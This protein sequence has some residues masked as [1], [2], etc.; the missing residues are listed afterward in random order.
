M[1][2]TRFFTSFASFLFACNPKCLFCFVF[3]LCRGGRCLVAVR[4]PPSPL[5]PKR[6]VGGQQRR[7]IATAD[8]RAH[9]LGRGRGEGRYAEQLSSCPPPSTWHFTDRRRDQGSKFCK[10]RSMWGSR[11][12][13]PKFL[14]QRLILLGGG[15]LTQYRTK[16]LGVP[17]VAHQ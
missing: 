17:I 14:N 1:K 10:D 13:C 11:R 3:V 15:V 16:V 5:G 9:L 12:M 4:T 8:P 2:Q 7:G 6:Q